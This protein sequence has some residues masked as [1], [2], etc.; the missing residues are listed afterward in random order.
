MPKKYK[1]NNLPKKLIG[2]ESIFEGTSRR[3]IEKLPEIDYELQRTHIAKGL[4]AVKSNLALH[5]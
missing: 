4:Q 3:F 1:H 2:S 5:E